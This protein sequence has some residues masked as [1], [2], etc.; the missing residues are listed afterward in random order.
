MREDEPALR[1]VDLALEPDEL[2]EDVV[3]VRV[4]VPEHRLL[5]GGEHARLDVAGPWTGQEALRGIKGGEAR[6]RRHGAKGSANP[7]EDPWN[8]RDFHEFGLCIE[9]PR[10]PGRFPRTRLA[11][12]DPELSTRAPR[13]R[14]RPPRSVR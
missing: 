6:R 8:P 2:R 7:R 14:V 5:H 1:L 3:Q 12:G 10:G 9:C 4:E 11:N 13:P